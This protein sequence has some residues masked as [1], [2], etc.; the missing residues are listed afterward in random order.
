MQEMP[1]TQVL[2]VVLFLGQKDPLEKEMAA[3]SSDLAW[4]IPQ[5][6]EPGRLQSVD[7]ESW[8]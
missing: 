2:S 7:L 8:T 1:E 3:H 5:T 6:D 4:R